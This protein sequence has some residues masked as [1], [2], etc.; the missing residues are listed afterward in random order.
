MSRKQV[1]VSLIVIV[2][3]VALYAL[4]RSSR[5]S[6]YEEETESPTVVA[7][8]VGRL[9]RVTLHGYVDGFGT[10][11]PAPASEGQPAAE[12]RVA[13]SVA[14]VVTQVFVAEGQTVASGA[15]LFELD[16]RAARVAVDAASQVA[17]RQKTLYEQKNTSLRSLQEA[18]AQLEAAKAQLAL[19]RVTAPI[20]GIVTRV[21]V[22]PGEAVDLATVLAVITDPHRLVV[23]ADIP[24]TDA[25]SVN[26]GQTVLISAVKPVSTKLSFVS[27]TIDPDNG[28]VRVRASVPGDSDLRSGQFVRL[29]I[30]TA[31]HTDAL[32]APAASVVTDDQGHS[33]VSVVS[34]DEA[35]QV[36]VKAG[37]HDSDLIEVEGTG[38]KEGDTVVTVGAYGLPEKTK[39]TIVD[40]SDAGASPDASGTPQ[41][42]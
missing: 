19:L 12:A 17:E 32:A 29:R 9:T 7:V 24:S 11:S 41:S 10:V 5:R 37:L 35:T 15:P 33:V 20:S 2:L 25:G 21:G 4:F 13:A 23:T 26:V 1:I 8:E 36:P 40:S 30:V 22:Q 39:V 31:T 3:G 14:G 18:E 6:T 28:A 42:Q 34:G 16:S 38:L 27:P